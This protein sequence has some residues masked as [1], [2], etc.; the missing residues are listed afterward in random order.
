[1]TPVQSRHIGR[2]EEIIRETLWMARRYAHG[3]STYAPSTV[4]QCIDTALKLGIEITADHVVGGMYADDGM[5]GKW[6][7]SIGQFQKETTS[8]ASSV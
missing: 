3:R 2:M 4:N 5:F 1:M 6:N 7:P 8:D